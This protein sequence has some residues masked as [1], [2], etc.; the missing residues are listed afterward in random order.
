[1]MLCDRDDDLVPFLDKRLTETGSDQVDGHR[2]PGGEN[3][4]LPAA[5][6]QELLDGVP[7]LLV[8]FGRIDSK[9]MDG[10]MDIGVGAGG[11]LTLL[12]QHSQRTLGRRRVVQIDKRLPIH[13]RLQGGELTP[14]FAYVHTSLISLQIYI[15]L[16]K[17]SF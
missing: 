4:F 15:F 5:G 2:G 11:Q 14:D 6:I 16:Y 3:D 13:L 8:L 12:F 1:M 9:L 7:G 17:L 10:P